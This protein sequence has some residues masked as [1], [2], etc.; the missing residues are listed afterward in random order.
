MRSSG[1]GQGR[2]PD[3]R[4]SRAV[5]ALVA[6][7]AFAPGLAGCAGSSQHAGGHPAPS[8]SAS[9]P[10]AVS[11]EAGTIHIDTAYAATS[12]RSDDGSMTAVYMSL[13]NS[14]G[15]QVSLVSATSSLAT[16]VELHNTVDTGNNAETMTAVARIPVPARGAVKL[17]PGGYHI[18]AMGLA[19]PLHVGDRMPLTLRFSDHHTIH[20]DLPVRSR[21]DSG[22]GDDMGDMKGMKGMPGMVLVVR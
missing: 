1:P 8:A 10:A 9:A 7:I 11:A 16:S 19:H 3:V 18:M 13:T 14:A 2:P 6:G 17:T 5:V 15:T 22:Q 20:L 4:L 12:V 21:V